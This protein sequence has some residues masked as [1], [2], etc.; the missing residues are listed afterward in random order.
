MASILIIEDEPRN[1][2]FL[3][4]GLEQLGHHTWVV[5]NQESAVPLA[6]SKMFD[7]VLL[8]LLLP[9][10]NGVSILSSIRE[11]RLQVPIIVMTALPSKEERSRALFLGANEYIVKPFHFEHLLGYIRTYA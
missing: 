2:S 9:E 8:D 1:V 5:T 7:I 6:L 3:A 10:L 11:R 4:Q